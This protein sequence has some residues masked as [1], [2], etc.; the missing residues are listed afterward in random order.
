M[1]TLFCGGHNKAR[2]R[3]FTC[4]KMVAVKR[5]REQTPISGK[6]LDEMQLSS[7]NINS[8]NEAPA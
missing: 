1:G 5:G 7:D 2:L 3:Q 6:N 4:F 8:C